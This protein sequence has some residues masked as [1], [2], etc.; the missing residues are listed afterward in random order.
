[1]RKAYIAKVCY[2]WVC[3]C[4]SVRQCV[5]FRQNVR[6][7]ACIIVKAHLSYLH[8]DAHQLGKGVVHRLAGASMMATT[9]EDAA[10]MMYSIYVTATK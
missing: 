8:I 2:V 4:N 7:F 5:C 1:M 3:A 10:G 9:M 6:N